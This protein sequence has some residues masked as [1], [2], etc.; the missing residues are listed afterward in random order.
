MENRGKPSESVSQIRELP[1]GQCAQNVKC[2][3]DVNKDKKS[4]Y[5][6][7][8]NPVIGDFSKGSFSGMAGMTEEQVR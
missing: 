5:L 4:V 3:R 6:F 7:W 1:E 8:Q 2:C